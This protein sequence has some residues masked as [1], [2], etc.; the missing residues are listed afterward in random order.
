M[1]E[2]RSTIFL[3]ILLLYLSFDF[4]ILT[5]A[6]RERLQ[7]LTQAVAISVTE[8]KLQLVELAFASMEA[9][10]PCVAVGSAHRMPKIIAR[11]IMDPMPVS[12][13]AKY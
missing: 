11:V 8:A 10:S 5:P 1:V 6:L 7:L 4:Q 3:C 12:V 2:G 9:L 13:N